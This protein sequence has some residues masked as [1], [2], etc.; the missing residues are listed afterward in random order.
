LRLRNGALQ[1]ARPAAGVQSKAVTTPH[2][3]TIVARRTQPVP[4]VS[5]HPRSHHNA[6]RVPPPPAL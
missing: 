1:L 4:D 2:G 3:A 5:R 6:L